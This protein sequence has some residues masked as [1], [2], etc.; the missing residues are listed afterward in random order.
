MVQPSVTR[1]LEKVNAVVRG[2]QKGH[3]DMYPELGVRDTQGDLRAPR[4]GLLDQL[5]AILG[6]DGRG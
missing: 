4:F 2:S 1:V 5:V 6:H 3:K